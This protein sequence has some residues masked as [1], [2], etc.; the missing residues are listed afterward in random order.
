MRDS[1]WDFNRFWLGKPCQKRLSLNRQLLMLIDLNMNPSPQA[2]FIVAPARSFL[3]P[4]RSGRS[5]TSQIVSFEHAKA[6]AA[7]AAS[8]K[9]ATRKL[10]R[11][12]PTSGTDPRSGPIWIGS[13]IAD[14]TSRAVASFL[15][16]CAGY[17]C[18]HGWL[19]LLARNSA[20]MKSSRRWAQAACDHFLCSTA[21]A[22]S[23]EYVHNVHDV[24]Q[25]PDSSDVRPNG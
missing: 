24:H 6:S 7:L 23:Y 13:G 2:G 19:L 1:L 17:N 9:R 16:C 5:G 20:L 21:S 10:T 25:G 8:C 11:A 12:K 15:T 4:R 14:N 22:C 3:K 18:A